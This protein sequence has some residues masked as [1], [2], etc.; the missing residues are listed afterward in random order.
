M[1]S[2]PEGSR[3]TIGGV[4]PLGIAGITFDFGNTLVRVD[5]AGLAAVVA[6]TAAELERHG[7]IAAVDAFTRVWAEERDRQFREEVP[8]FREVDLDQ[9]VIRVLARLRGMVTPSSG[10]RWDDVAAGRLVHGDEVSLTV[11]AYSR[12]FVG[13]MV[14]LPEAEGTL[15]RLSERGFTMGILSNWPL[16]ATIDR[17]V[18]AHGWGPPLLRA[19]VVSQRVGTIKPHPR[20]FQAAASAM[21]LPPERLLHVGDDWSADVAGALA[22]GWHAAYLRGHQ[23]DSPLPTSEPGGAL[24]A[25]LRGTPDLVLD[26][27]AELDPRV[28]LVPADGVGPTARIDRTT[29]PEVT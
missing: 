22:A 20:I 28:T 19:V 23:E 26:S 18:A 17:Y 7:S 14:P 29:G 16:A 24:A 3:S 2:D 8:R 1:A 5:R 25:G 12:A 27:L 15:R 13:R 6:D 9:R 21:G 11:T 10:D 4:P